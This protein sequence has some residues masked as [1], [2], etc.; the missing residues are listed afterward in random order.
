M[1]GLAAIAPPGRLAILG[2]RGVPASHG[3][4]ETF[5]ERLAV[6]LA[7]AGWQV[8]VACQSDPPGVD[9]WRGVRCVRLGSGMSNPL[10]TLLFDARSV[11]QAL[12][13][14]DPVLVLGY[15]TAIFWLPLRMA[16]IKIVAN[17]DG[18]EWARAKWSRPIK[19]WLRANEWAAAKLANHLV[20]DHPTIAARAKQLARSDRV[21]MIPYGADR[22]DASDSAPLGMLHLRPNHYALVVA[23]PEPENS[24]LEIVAAYCR[25]PR[26]LPLVVLGRFDP[27]NRY[28]NLVLAAAGP[29]VIFPGAIYDADV[30]AA[31]RTHAR[32]YI[33]GHTVGGTNP[34]LV[35][36]LASGC[37][38]LA[39]D[40]DFNR[41]VAGSGIRYFK[42][43]GS[44]AESLD[45]LLAP[46]ADLSAMR[47]W[48]YA[49]ADEAF[50]WEPILAE[51]AGLILRIQPVARDVSNSQESR[52]LWKH[53]E[54]SHLVR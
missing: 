21:T 1:T 14:R 31:L 51:Y 12:Q 32:L 25:V 49:R 27:R 5:A 39:H 35:E 23:R 47:E 10:G 30:I 36:A 48:A 19:W 13:W 53:Q 8:T 26:E 37:P 42:D 24:F 40:N 45:A 50:R 29:G 3:G 41:W 11:L 18:L 7:S 44:C 20:A 52:G 46:G 38:V 2:C 54:R 15:N 16:G 9:T 34:S 33:H 17:M 43:T 6:N 28:H 22:I 4:F